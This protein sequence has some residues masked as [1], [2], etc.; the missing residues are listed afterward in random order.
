MDLDATANKLEEG[1][2]DTILLRRLT[3][4]G[5]YIQVKCAARINKWQIERLGQIEA[6]GVPERVFFLEVPPGPPRPRRRRRLVGVDDLGRGHHG[7]GPWLAGH[8]DPVLGLGAHHPQHAHINQPMPAGP[9]L[10]R[11]YTTAGYTTGGHR[12]WPVLATV[13]IDRPASAPCLPDTR[14]RM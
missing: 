8:R 3:G 2:S 12:Y 1:G 7:V 10:R 13:S 9:Q 11:R 5:A 6:A 14:V 4:R